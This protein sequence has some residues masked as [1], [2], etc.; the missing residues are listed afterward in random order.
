LSLQL[1]KRLVEGFEVQ[2]ALEAS[3]KAEKRLVQVRLPRHI[4]QEMG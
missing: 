2:P 4:V 3:R 1:R